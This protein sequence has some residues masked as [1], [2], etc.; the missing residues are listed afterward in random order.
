[1][2]HHG[3]QSLF[4]RSP[5]R[6]RWHAPATA[7]HAGRQSILVGCPVTTSHDAVTPSHDAVAT[8]GHDAP[9]APAAP[10]AAAG[11]SVSFWRAVIT[12]T[13]NTTAT[14]WGLW[15]TNVGN[16]SSGGSESFR[17][18]WRAN[19]SGA[20]RQRQSICSPHSCSG[21]RTDPANVPI[22]FSSKYDD[23]SVPGYARELYPS[24]GRAALAA[25]GLHSQHRCPCRH[26]SFWRGR[27][28]YGRRRRDRLDQ[29]DKFIQRRTTA[30]SGFCHKQFRAASAT[31]GARAA[32]GCSHLT[33]RRSIEISR[34]SSIGSRCEI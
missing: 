7:G 25:G 13:T 19:A 5:G 23:A 30:V 14:T 12:C 3:E 29:S 11:Q 1:M 17:K 21:S 26:Q 27:K 18:L 31:A 9:S 15:P 22:Y 6:R 34:R 32:A 16:S 33:A 24:D 2:N 20:R 8:T 28:D 4:I 10:P